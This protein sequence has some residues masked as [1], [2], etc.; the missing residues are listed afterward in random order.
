MSAMCPISTN[1]DQNS[2]QQ[3]TALFDYLV[4]A[5]QEAALVR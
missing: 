3:K 1:I 2:L 4:G 5:G